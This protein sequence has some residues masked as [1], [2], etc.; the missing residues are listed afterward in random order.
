MTPWLVVQWGAALV[1][2]T[3]MM[4]GAGMLVAWGMDRLGNPPTPGAGSDTTLHKEG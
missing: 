1:T 3:L 4:F 2:V